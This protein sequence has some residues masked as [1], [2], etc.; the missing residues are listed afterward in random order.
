[1]PHKKLGKRA[2][3]DYSQKLRRAVQ[4]AFLVLNL[5][6]GIQFFLFVRYYETGG[7][8]LRVTRPAGV[9]GWLPIAALMNLKALLFTGQLPAIHPAGTLLLVAFLAASWIFRKSFC[10]WLCPVGTVSDYLARLGR[11]LFRRNFHFPKLLDIPLRGL[12]YVLLLLF[13]YAVVS[14]PVPAIRQ[15]LDSPYGVVD[16][17]KMLNFFRELGLTGGIV[18]AVLAVASLFIQNFW[19]RYLCP[20]GALMGIVSTLSPVK[21]RRDAS[22]CIDCNKCNKAC[23]SH[24]PVAQLLTI[25]SVECTGCLSCIAACPAENALQFALPPHHITPNATLSTDTTIRAA[26]T[27]TRWQHRIVQ[28]R[29]VAAILAIIFFTLIGIARATGHWQTP[30]SRDVY[31]QLVPNA[32]TYTH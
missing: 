13:V 7:H 21:I 17:V 8:T 2:P 24:L 15:F 6:I 11:R 3:K 30:I 4:A 29:A 28:P 25:R 1:M 19:C 31:M 16:D 5:W 18:M 20:Y 14:M 27:A 23:P 9:E 32:D 12:K 22:A 10:G 26:N